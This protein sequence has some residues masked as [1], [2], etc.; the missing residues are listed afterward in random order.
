MAVNP[1]TPGVYIEEIPKFPASIAGVATAVP[2][3]IGYVEKA[4][5]NGVGIPFNTPVRI[6]SLLEYQSI[7]GKANGQMFSIDINDNKN[8]SP[9]QRSI[10]VSKS[11][12][13]VFTMYYNVQMYYS[14]GG[15]PCYVVPVGLY[16]SASVSKASLLAGLTAIA[17]EDEPTLLLFPDAVSLTAPGERKEVYD[18]AL[19]QCQK[20]KDRFTIMDV[21]HKTNNTV[22][23]DA[24]DF[25]NAGIG[26]DNLKYGASYYPFL[27][28]TLGFGINENLVH[29]NSQKVNGDDYSDSAPTIALL[30]A[31]E[32]AIQLTQQGFSVAKMQVVNLQKDFISA[33]SSLITTAITAA[34][35]AMNPTLPAPPP[36]TPQPVVQIVT[37]ITTALTAAKTYVT[38]GNFFADNNTYATATSPTRAQADAMIASYNQLVSDLASIRSVAYN[39]LNTTPALNDYVIGSLANL[40]NVNPA[41][42]NSISSQISAYSLQLNPSGAMAGIYA[43]VDNERGVWKAP[44]NV[45]VRSIT[46]PSIN[47]TNSEQDDL[48]IDATSGKSINVIRSF[49]GRG[50]LVWGARTLAG[51]DNE[52]RYIN[53]RRLFNYVEES[54][55]EA[56]MFVVFEPNTANTWQRVKG[57]IESFLTSLWRE[58][59]LA[60]A[61]TKDAFFVNVG[62]GQTM[63]AQD[64]LEGRLIVEVGMAA[65]RPAEFIILQF[66]HKL[67]ES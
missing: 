58:G 67:Q 16:D 32:N 7:F 20:L 2:A 51:N 47:V 39:I 35:D 54:V 48:N 33:N 27:N 42:Y 61:T 57:M 12:E 46:G 28:T 65:V 62:L 15:G 14:N 11:A 6:T 52:W 44:A 66:E 25:R 29:I 31:I 4:E 23:Q 60:G 30:N 55:Q 53:V 13:S 10:T 38:S 19:A 22:F 26:P 18:A 59:A 50:T 21:V 3:F 34:F 8:V 9:T 17:K 56:T 37:A 40:K 5:N 24:T 41:V 63:T 36:P 64:I 49:T 1:K 43:R 45:G